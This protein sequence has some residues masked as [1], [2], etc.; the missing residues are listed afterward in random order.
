[1]TC[2]VVDNGGAFEARGTL[3]LGS[4]ALEF[5]VGNISAEATENQP[6]LGDVSYRSL[7]TIKLY[8]SPDDPQCEFFFVNSQDIVSGRVWMNFT[9]RQIANASTNN[10]CAISFG[11]IALQNCEQ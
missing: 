8:M 3:E 6:A 9:C 2:R 4:N 11:T 7:D 10:S 5:S 1:V